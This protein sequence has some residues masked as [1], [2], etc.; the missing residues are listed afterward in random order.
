MDDRNHITDDRVAAL[1]CRLINEGEIDETLYDL[2]CHRSYK[3]LENRRIG[4]KSG[5]K[6]DAHSLA[7][8]C[9]LELR[10]KQMTHVQSEGALAH[11][12]SKY[13]TRR[14][15]PAF[16]EVWKALSH[17][18]LELEKEGLVQRLS[19]SGGANSQAT[20]W[21]IAGASGLPPAILENFFKDASELTIYRPARKDGRLLA[22]A[23]ARELA[24]GMLNLAHGPILMQSLHG[25]AMKH[26]VLQ[27]I[28]PE[29]IELNTGEDEGM[30]SESRDLADRMAVNDY[31]L[32]E[33]AQV[34]ARQIWDR[35][36]ESGDGKTLCMYYIPK[37]LLGASV[38]GNDLGD[39]RRISESG[40]RIREAFQEAIDLT[41]T[42]AECQES[43][44]MAH[45]DPSDG[46]LSGNQVRLLGRIAETLM[47]FCSEKSW[48]SNLKSTQVGR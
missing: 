41:P 19:P 18:L 37:H 42:L 35:L 27:M 17:A 22:P 44:S 24:L 1:I 10:T 16:H 23:Q 48:D 32:Q 6:E 5:L 26:V 20:E 34:R 4:S 2:A 43:A 14:E 45:R 33:E 28:Y 46:G 30:K 8:D 31:I 47:S 36:E 21:C 40:K 13:L 25:E 7:I 3:L 38:T 15:S 9:L 39:P 12:L 11:E 29:S